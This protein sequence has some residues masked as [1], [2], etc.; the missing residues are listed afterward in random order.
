MGKRA[1]FTRTSQP[2]PA[3][4]LHSIPNNSNLTST[5]KHAYT[6]SIPRKKK[7]STERAKLGGKARAEKLTPAQRKASARKAARARW[8]KG[9]DA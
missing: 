5:H 9:K 8:A 1:F 2:K 7:T 6:L 4:D 3:A